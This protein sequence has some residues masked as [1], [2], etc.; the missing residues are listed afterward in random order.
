MKERVTLNVNGEEKEILIEPWQTLLSV[1]RDNLDLTGAKNPCGVG[2]CGACTVLV[3][4]HPVNACLMLA[5]DARGKEIV[6]IEGL[7]PFDDP[8]PLQRSFYE[9]G[10]IQCGMCT[11]GMI[12]NAKHLLDHNHHPSEAEIRQHIDGH[13]CR[14]T[15]YNKIVLAIQKVAEQTAK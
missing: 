2:E 3:N 7:A 12:I 14:C 5:M 13:I 10:A 15:G 4:D 11:P 1:L 8:H 9:E 6:T